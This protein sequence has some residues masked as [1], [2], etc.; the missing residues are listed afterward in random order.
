MVIRCSHCRG[1]MRLDESRIPKDGGAKVRCPRCG[2]IDY[3]EE[4]SLPK[5]RGQDRVPAAGSRAPGPS[6]SRGPVSSSTPR[7][8]DPAGRTEPSIPAD[9]FQG[10]RFPGEREMDSVSN[11]SS[12]TWKRILV[13]GFVSLGVVVVFA[14]LVNIVLWGPAG[15]KPF[16]GVKPSEGVERN[17]TEN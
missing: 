16:S 14:L 15:D 7:A 9:A 12:S 13:W 5:S 10:F 3:V 6:A 2:E 11:R 17:T 1:M 8:G 4:S